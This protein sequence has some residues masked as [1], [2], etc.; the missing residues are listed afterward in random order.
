M[1]YTVTY[2][3]DGVETPAVRQVVEVD[4]GGNVVQEITDGKGQFTVEAEDCE[5][6][7]T[8][9]K[10]LLSTFKYWSNIDT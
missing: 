5:V 1:T 10:I 9:T 3:E 4:I 8:T 7:C 2:S 6:H